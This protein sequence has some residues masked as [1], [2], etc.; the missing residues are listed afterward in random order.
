MTLLSGCG[1]PAGSGARAPAPTW[2]ADLVFGPRL[3]VPGEPDP[4]ANGPLRV[5]YFSPVHEAGELVGLTAIFNLELAPSA[6]SRVFEID[7]PVK[8]SL[9]FVGR[10]VTFRSEEPFPL[11]ARYYVSVP[12]S[13]VSLDGRGLDEEPLWSV[14]TPRP[15]LV[16]ADAI[17]VDR[18]TVVR[19]RYNQAVDLG[20]LERKLSVVARRKPVPY[21]LVA[22]GEP[23]VVHVVPRQRVAPGTSMQ[24]TIQLGVQG[25]EGRLPSVQTE[26]RT[27]SSQGAAPPKS[28]AVVGS[29]VVPGVPAAA[30][31]N[32]VN[33]CPDL[34]DGAMLWGETDTAGGPVMLPVQ[35]QESEF[36]DVS[37]WPATGGDALRARRGEAPA[38]EG[39]AIGRARVR[40]QDGIAEL[41][42]I[43]EGRWLVEV[44]PESAAANPAETGGGCVLAVQRASLRVAAR[45]DAV[46]AVLRVADGNGPVVADVAWLNL[47]GGT[48]GTARTSAA[49]GA[50]LPVPRGAVELRA[51]SGDRR[52]FSGPVAS[53]VL[54]TESV[55]IF[56]PRAVLRVGDEVHVVG[57]ARVP[58]LELVAES[59]GAVVQSATVRVVDGG[60]SWAWPL[61]DL[62]AGPLLVTARIPGQG[63][64]ARVA[65]SIAHARP[66]TGVFEFVAGGGATAERSP[67]DVWDVPVRAALANGLPWSGEVS[68]RMSGV[69][70]EAGRTGSI[71]LDGDGLGSVRV[72]VPAAPGGERT[73]LRLALRATELAGAAP[74]FAQTTLR[75]T[76]PQ[77]RLRPAH[78]VLRPGERVSVDVDVVD[79]DGKSAPGWRGYV[80]LEMATGQ[81][82][83]RGSPCLFDAPGRG[84]Q[85]AFVAPGVGAGRLRFVAA[86]GQASV[87][88]AEAAENAVEVTVP[89]AV[90][91]RG[92]RPRPDQPRLWV[93]GASPARVLVVA[94]DELTLPPFRG[95]RPV[96]SMRPSRGPWEVFE[97][98]GA[99]AWVGVGTEWTTVGEVAPDSL[100]VSVSV[101]PAVVRPGD[102]VRV[103]IKTRP[104]ARAAVHCVDGRSGGAR[105]D[106][107]AP[108]IGGTA[109]VAEGRTDASGE[110]LVERSL[111]ASL[112]RHALVA[113]VH[114]GKGRAGT[115][116]VYAQTAL[117]LVLTGDV[118]EMVTTRDTAWA[119][120]W[121]RSRTAHAGVVD[122]ELGDE[123]RR[124]ELPP[125]ARTGVRFA[126]PRT[127]GEHTL[128]ARATPRWDCAAADPCPPA[129]SVSAEFAL[130]VAPIAA[131]RRFRAGRAAGAATRVLEIPAGARTTLV[132]SARS[133]GP[134]AQD[135]GSLDGP[136]PWAL[137]RALL[138]TE[139]AEALHR[140]VPVEQH[141]E[142]MRWVR[143][144][145]ESADVSPAARVVCAVM[146]SSEDPLEVQVL[147]DL[148]PLSAVEL[149]IWARAWLAIAWSR[150]L[151]NVGDK[152]PLE[153][154]L[155]KLDVPAVPDAADSSGLGS[156]ALTRASVL[157]ALLELRPEDPRVPGLVRE[158][159]ARRDGGALLGPFAEAVE[160]L[161]LRRLPRRGSL[162]PPMP[163]EVWVDDVRTK[164]VGLGGAPERIVLGLAPGRHELVVAGPAD[165]AFWHALEMVWPEPVSPTDSGF[166]VSR[167]LSSSEVRVGDDVELVV[168]YVVTAPRSF[169][170]VDGGLP[171]NF[172]VVAGAPVMRADR[173]M[174]GIYTLRYTLRAE[175]AGFWF[176]PPA[177]AQAAEQPW[178][179]G[180]STTAHI[181]VR[182]Q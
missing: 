138:D 47:S 84:I 170:T 113:V 34:T 142:A 89:V 72:R 125:G 129:G 66:V 46:D 121:V 70:G 182:P 92:Y 144:R 160:E 37:W 18:A 105:P 20:V 79:V 178:I 132:L 64:A 75:P 60:F 76:R 126:L 9:A 12:L 180:A 71:V 40:V 74:L 139:A 3:P 99:P 59:A 21:V 156:V 54:A 1:D 14:A 7:P 155:R 136:L 88:A 152:R 93:S 17:E 38:R 106:P 90:V 15:E 118:P 130:Q 4:V 10:A 117:P 161:A 85:C 167:T 119:E 127:A 115:S 35:L 148:D 67:G 52:G 63:G 101:D 32:G 163:I 143:E 131:Q 57:A 45:R 165:V 11:A 102:P 53:Q 8:G 162:G 27:L 123:S 122:V 13:A 108:G 51:V 94:N 23:G 83:K 157:L 141:A 5:V 6:R 65:L 77:L 109:W 135:D 25:L 26:R 69:A 36:V 42:S 128:V 176:V 73:T 158:I 153:Q 48:L 181:R 2:R 49:G 78:T 68:W 159:V 95:A 104:G 175:R 107:G 19:L 171:T 56:A 169:V 133:P 168:Q 111:P 33:R 44:T 112:G 55:R 134:G 50:R 87:A 31:T 166:S 116:V 145:L 100:A 140:S 28:S 62:P 39:R 22:P 98:D 86:P 30:E 16:E 124:V 150:R 114:D 173:V 103:R 43:P 120:I 172:R 80:A 110:L 97:V 29:G 179:F 24:L 154:A 174:P 137:R 91:G 151:R 96:E 147:R 82:W 41:G 61:P 177:T 146:L 58:A 164:R 81:G 149:P